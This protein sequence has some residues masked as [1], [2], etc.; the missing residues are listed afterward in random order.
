[1]GLRQL[2]R[3]QSALEV[4]PGTPVPTATSKWMGV[5]TATWH[6]ER[7]KDSPEEIRQSL[8]RYF[9]A[10]TLSVMGSVDLE[11]TCT[12]EE[13]P[14]VLGAGV[15]GGV[16][17]VTDGGSPPGYAYAYTPTLTAVDTPNTYTLQVGDDT[18]AY[19]MEYSF[20]RNFELSFAVRER[21]RLRSSWVGRQ[22]TTGS[23]TGA[24]GDR[25]IED[26]FGQGWLAY[27]DNQGGSI[28]ATQYAGCIVNGTWR[29]PQSFIPHNCID[30]TNTFTRHQMVS[31]APELELT[32][33]LDST[34]NSTRAA[35]T[36]DTHKLI[37]LRNS[38]TIIHGSVHK[39]I[40]IDGAYQITD[41]GAVGGSDQD[42]VQTLRLTARGEYDSS[43]SL[44]FSIEVVNAVS[45]LP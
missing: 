3:V 40:T 18:Q 45:A 5:Y 15:K 1:M 21:S 43:A 14:Y 38:G 22:L 41:W 17:G 6:E 4:T 44:L 28:G 34:A 10:T 16:S 33:E 9:R 13:L 36:S 32:I 39:R 30:G 35:Y 37:R 27:I 7:T 19:L 26:A 11:Q 8:A 12:F 23:F 24:L 42:G 29:L 20:V 25:T 31:L 2:A